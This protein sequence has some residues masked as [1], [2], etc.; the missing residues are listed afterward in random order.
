MTSG[1]LSQ[2]FDLIQPTPARGALTISR[3][4]L[5]VAPLGLGLLFSNAASATNIAGAG[6]GILGYQSAVNSSPG[7]LLFHA[8]T[9]ANINDAD[10]TTQVDNFSGGADGG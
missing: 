10:Y 2:R 6:T 3:L 5:T 9:P 1:E 8:G 4:L 7:V